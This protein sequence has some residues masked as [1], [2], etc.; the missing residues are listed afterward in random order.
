MSGNEGNILAMLKRTKQIAF[1]M[2][3]LLDCKKQSKV[4]VSCGVIAAVFDSDLNTTRFIS[5]ACGGGICIFN[6]SRN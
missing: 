5:F 2:A 4:G 6:P 1:I 3:S